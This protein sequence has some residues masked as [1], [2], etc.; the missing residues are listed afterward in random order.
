MRMHVRVKL[1]MFK[2]NVFVHTY[3]QQESLTEYV[4][5]YK[6]V[7]GNVQERMLFKYSII[8]AI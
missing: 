2:R 4:R 5:P 3:C 7:C 1:K 6:Q 8:A